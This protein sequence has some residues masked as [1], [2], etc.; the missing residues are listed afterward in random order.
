MRAESDEAMPELAGSELALAIR[1]L[2]DDIPIVLMSGYVTTALT[3]RAREAGVADVLAKPLVG[4]D[5][6]RALAAAFGR[7]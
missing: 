2:R 3:Q 4:R 7:A 6:A 1:G 5:I